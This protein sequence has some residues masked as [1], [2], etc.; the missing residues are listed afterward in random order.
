MAD[1]VAEH[2]AQHTPRHR[3]DARGRGRV[4]NGAYG[5]DAPA[6]RA[7]RCPFG[8]RHRSD[9]TAARCRVHAGGRGYGR[10]R[11]CAADRARV[12]RGTHWRRQGGRG[13]V[14]VFR[15]MERLR[16]C[17]RAG[18]A[19]IAGAVLVEHGAAQRGDHGGQCAD[20]A[21]QHFGR[22]RAAVCG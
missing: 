1:L 17:D 19:A 16:R 22:G 9:G 10:G 15:A 13:P 5:F 8:S 14:A 7:D 6:G 11:R 2:A 21:P 20:G 18:R 3:A 4:L 12:V